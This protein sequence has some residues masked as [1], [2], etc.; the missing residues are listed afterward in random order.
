MQITCPKCT[1]K[2]NVQDDLIPKD[3]RLVQCGSCENKWFFKNIKPQSYKSR[4]LDKLNYK[5]E[6]QILPKKINKIEKQVKSTLIKTEKKNNID[7][8]KNFEKKIN[9]F[10][11]FLVLI[12][13][14]IAMIVIIDTFKNQISSIYPDINFILDNLYESLRDIKLFLNDL[15]K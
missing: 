10:K 14:L 5:N 11:L 8:S 6:K 2:F 13:S 9:Y 12:I 4:N 7:K 3:G 15:I 1:K